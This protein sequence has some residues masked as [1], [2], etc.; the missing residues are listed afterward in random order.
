[1]RPKQIITLAIVLIALVGAL[2]SAKALNRPRIDTSTYD[3]LPISVDPAAIYEIQI[4][5]TDEA[6]PVV[7]QKSGDNWTLPRRSGGR[8][9]S[10]KVSNLIEGFSVVE[11]ELRSTSKALLSTFGIEKDEAFRLTFFAM[12]GKELRS[13]YVG[14][15]S[16]YQQHS[17]LREA[18]SNDVYWVGRNLFSLLGVFGDPQKA[19][20]DYQFWTDLSLIPFD[21]QTVDSFKVVKKADGKEI[22]QVSLKKDADSGE[23]VWKDGTGHAYFDLSQD[24]I[25]GFL[26]ILKNNR[27]VRY[28]SQEDLKEEVH[29][30]GDTLQIT[31][32]TAGEQYELIMGSPVDEEGA[33][34]FVRAGEWVFEHSTNYLD[35][36]DV[37]TSRFYVR[38][39]LGI[40]P[41]EIQSVVI[42]DGRKE[43][44][45][46]SEEAGD[47]SQFIDR[48]KYIEFDRIYLGT[49]FDESEVKYVLEVVFNNEK[50]TQKMEVAR[51]KADE[52]VTRISGTAAL[53]YLSQRT[54]DELFKDPKN[55]KN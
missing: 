51:N 55:I 26:N 15:K 21:V 30:G 4:E 6:E 12:G 54:F 49:A 3:V 33:T 22:V 7:I 37:D 2:V 31:L 34:H 36:W 24:E 25:N 16:S 5:K 17:F 44:R 41:N 32:S 18:Q 52:L 42:K 53:F 38:N 14:G 50:P 46:T 1:M 10:E 8:A 23:T 29:F 35:L 28:V 19:S 13:Y 39:V 20:P 43:V 27:A 40:Q 45:F 48:M 47:Y 11:G 9:K